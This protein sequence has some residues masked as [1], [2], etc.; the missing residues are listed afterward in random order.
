M[1]K[2]GC[3]L[4]DGSD[5]N[6]IGNIHSLNAALREGVESCVLQNTTTTALLQFQNPHMLS[7]MAINTA[8]IG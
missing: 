5:R 2:I 4:L 3:Q 8:A 6:A 1:A 7:K